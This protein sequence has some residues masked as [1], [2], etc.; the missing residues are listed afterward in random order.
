MKTPTQKTA[1]KVAKQLAKLERMIDDARFV[2]NVSDV[3]K[4]DLTAILQR[5][6]RARQEAE[7]VATPL[8]E[9]QPRRWDSDSCRYVDP[10]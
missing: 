2:D 5:L 8:P 10:N 9:A 7:H 3:E 1:D 4:S 6:I